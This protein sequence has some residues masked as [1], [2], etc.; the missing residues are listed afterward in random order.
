MAA[1]SKDEVLRRHRTWHVR[2]QAVTDPLFDHSAFFDPRDLLVVTCEML[3]RLRLEG[4]PLAPTARR[5]GLSRATCYQAYRD[6]QQGGLLALVPET[7]GPRGPHKL[8]ADV[9][10]FLSQGAGLGGPGGAAA[11]AE[12]LWHERA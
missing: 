9:L 1:L 6:W 10:A 7:P 4:H 11:L 5:F 8:T 3:R 2:A 12:R